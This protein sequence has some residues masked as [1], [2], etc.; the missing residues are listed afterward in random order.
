MQLATYREL[1][2]DERQ[3]VQA[4]LAACDECRAQFEAF[5][6]QDVL[7]AALP[8]RLPRR[9]LQVERGGPGPWW[10]GLTRLGNLMAAGGLAAFTLATGL[11]VWAMATSALAR[12][13]S[14][15]SAPGALLTPPPDLPALVNPW[16]LAAPWLG[17]S[18]FV[19]GAL[20]AL[21]RRSR[22]FPTL[23]LALAA[24]WVF[25][26]V[27]PLT[28]LP[29]P[30]GLIWRAAGGYSYDPSLPFRNFFVLS[31]DPAAKLR[32]HL[33]RLIGQVGLD[34]LDPVQ[35][36]ARYAI[37]RVTQPSD[38]HVVLVTTRFVYAN[39]SSRVFDVPVFDPIIDLYISNWQNDG[40]GRL[41][42]E[43]L[44]LP[45]QPFATESSPVRLG[46]AM[47]LQVS[48]LADR[49]DAINPF[50]WSWQNNRQQ[51]LAWSPR[52]DAFLMVE[53]LPSNS[54]QQ[55]WLV[56]LDGTAPQLVNQGGS[57]LEYGWSPDGAF[58]VYTAPE[59]FRPLS[60][61]Y[62]EKMEIV[63]VRRD[64]LAGGKGPVVRRAIASASQPDLTHQG[65]WYVQDG[66][67]WLMDYETGE[68]ARVTS[69]P[70][71]GPPSLGLVSFLPVAVSPDGSRLA[72]ACG[73]TDLCL[74]DLDG[75]ERRT[76]HATGIRAITWDPTGTRLAATSLDYNNFGPVQ[77]LI[78]SRDGV[79]QHQ[80]AV[81][82]S[83]ATDPPQWTPALPDGTSGQ[84]VFVQT[85]P[86]NGRRILTVNADTGDV[87]DLSRAH[88]DTYFALSPDGKSLL[89]NNGRGGFWLAPVI[90]Q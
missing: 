24:L 30:A 18:L 38:K 80:V 43:H 65:I 7:L 69:L 4:H 14:A 46:Q 29:N 87:L 22:V 1:T 62:I 25:T 41:R 31:G 83:D 70:D 21:G 15:P 6:K 9:Q 49:L 33:D 82:P 89:L 34:P 2:P 66:A 40:L 64:A 72:Y 39:G 19:I 86:M 27:P 88:W 52:Q 17:G 3:S 13:G 73:K 8:E 67:L 63:V 55:L 75:R 76:L 28:A 45:G 57:V 77:L 47:R 54:L 48:P 51:H 26:Y 42:T 12:T 79:V 53:H 81:A 78:V 10:N 74:S 35:P 16:A 68:S 5:R 36:L 37:E 23:G 32:P 85:Y 60:G 58:I 90:R 61:S 84:I 71:F 59:R 20:L 50:H 11:I 56:L 44:A